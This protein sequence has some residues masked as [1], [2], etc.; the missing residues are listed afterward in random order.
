MTS[1]ISLNAQKPITIEHSCSF[2][3]TLNSDRY[4]IFDS[5]E[6]AE[7][8]LKRILDYIG[9]PSNFKLQASTVPNA[10]AVIQD[11]QRYIFY[12]QLFMD[13][14]ADR[15]DTDWAAISILA[16]EIGHH[17][18]GHTLDD[19]RDRH[20]MELEADV[21][22]GYVL[23]RM[24]ATK[25]EAMIAVNELAD[26]TS[27]T[28][29][30]SKS[31]R[32]IAVANGWIK[33]KDHSNTAGVV[34][35]SAET[36]K[37]YV[38]QIEKSKT[39]VIRDLIQNAGVRENILQFGDKGIELMFN[40]TTEFLEA[41]QYR[42]QL[43]LV[44]VVGTEGSTRESL[45]YSKEYELYPNSDNRLKRT[46]FIPYSDL[47]NKKGVNKLTAKAVLYKKGASDGEWV[48]VSR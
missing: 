24:G 19:N 1:A 26:E 5:D 14:L 25:E 40:F 47:P 43:D 11:N 4:Y 42:L 15:T 7:K 20:T 27:T 41:D 9:L 12:N 2:H 30:P 21:F 23:Q 37:P 38:P 18:S 33:A 34:T 3:G 16:H 36:P 35:Q 39:I 29:H 17:L 46:L 13:H 45:S 8:V 6:N 22:S 48:P 10:S 32:K 28:T 31:D 44:S